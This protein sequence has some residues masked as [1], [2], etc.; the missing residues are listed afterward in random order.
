MSHDLVPGRDVGRNTPASPGPAGAAWLEDDR[1][2]DA[3]IG[4]GHVLRLLRRSAGTIA[5]CTAVALTAGAAVVYLTTPTYEVT[6]AVQIES[7]Q[8]AL[9]SA[10]RTLETG[11]EVASG[12][13]V[14]RSRALAEGVVDTL[15]LG[16]R[17]TKPAR[18]RRSAVFDQVRVA[19]AAGEAVF[20]LRRRPDSSF[21][22]FVAG[23]SE[24]RIA[25][26]APGRRLAVGDV[27]L[28]LGRGALAHEELQVEVEPFDDVVDA[29]R[30]NLD[31][32]RP[33]REAN[34][35]RIAY[36]STDPELARDVVNEL[37]TRFVDY[38]DG[39]RKTE[40]RSSAAFLEKQVD[41]LTRE[42]AAA[43]RELR[44]FRERERV[45]NPEVEGSTQVT[46]LAQLQAE[47]GALDGERRALDALLRTLDAQAGAQPADAPSVY[48]RLLGF[49]TLLRNQAAST[50]LI[51]LNAVE[52]ERV[53]L[54]K[55]RT[56][57]DPEV[58]ALTARMR[59]LEE[60]LRAT[61]TT[62]LSGLTN[63]VASS[64][65]ELARSG[66]V[67]AA[68]P[69]KEVQ[70][71]QLQREP[72][73]LA[74]MLTLLQTRLKEAQIA[75]AMDDP[76]VRVLDRAVAPRR[77]VNPRPAR[78][79]ALAGCVGVLLGVTA[80]ATRMR[81]DRSVHSR[82]DALFA[83]GVPVLGVVP[84]FSQ[85]QRR[86]LARGPLARGPL[87][88]LAARGER[89]AKA[90][91]DGVTVW[92][93]AEQ[94][95]LAV[96]EAYARLFMSIAWTLTPGA[97]TTLAITSALPEDGK[98]TTATN[99]AITLAQRGYRVL[100]VDADLRRG[101][102]GTLFKAP[103]AAGLAELL[104]GKA[105]LEKVLLAIDVGYDATLTYVTA[106]APPPQPAALLQS[107]A[108]RALHADFCRRYDVV[109]YDTP[110]LN[111]VSDAAILGTLAD[112]VLLVARAGKTPAEALALAAEQ[113]RI[114]RVPVRGVVLN[115]VDL[116]DDRS[117]AYYYS[118]NQGAY[119]EAPS[120]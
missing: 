11:N 4:A 48:R 120:A 37:A 113:L 59:E 108:M 57:R 117:Y 63:Q 66:R 58:V 71:A 97:P 80:G 49:P 119:A 53:E 110:P 94:Q 95:A 115:D 68:L 43:E 85:L 21:A 56:A 41:T 3:P 25:R 61:A 55:R 24:P 73:V 16:V 114:A 84:N 6:A 46:R 28:V 39:V 118:A 22:V 44:R 101:Q 54:L 83:S 32:G 8:G 72:R 65:L 5:A 93:A 104:R 13:E 62:Y 15:A 42:L 51:A 38:R 100:L 7:K 109:V 19:R 81:L 12:V 9:P 70:F 111:A 78:D 2:P 30:E 105:L 64:D 90:N 52:A 17:V 92:R 27:V 91:A 77:P 99:L 33:A 69:G 20:T 75:E 36:R 23:E 34:V 10:Y 14:M 87:A 116:K 89:G 82:A 47:R 67:L 40:A 79:L 88:A 96:T 35:V 60:Q 18:V 29:L 86:P 50:Y 76:S 45:V 107:E 98:T 31:I 102:V 106:G 103:K 26:V 1:G 74:E 112:G